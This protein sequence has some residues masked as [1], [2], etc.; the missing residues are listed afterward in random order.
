MADAYQNA[1]ARKQALLQELHKVEQFLA[2]YAEFSGSATTPDTGT[3]HTPET[4]RASS[5]TASA[6]IVDASVEAIEAAGRP[7]SRQTLL[8]MLHGRG[9]QIG[10]KDP[11]ATLGSALWRA[12]DTVVS[13]KGFGYW[14]RQRSFPEAGYDPADP[15]SPGVTEWIK[16]P[17]DDADE[18]EGSS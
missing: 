3:A 5:K 11:G 4:R 9:I 12:K 14:L 8:E 2:L 6:T 7:L 1:L 13:L 18:Q 17:D 10:G 15:A 16:A